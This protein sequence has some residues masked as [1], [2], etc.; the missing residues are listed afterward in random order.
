MSGTLIDNRGRNGIYFSQLLALKFAAWLE[1]NFEVWVFKTANKILFGHYKQH[2]D[3]HI[4]QEDAKTR[5][6]AAKSKL[7]VQPLQEDVIAYFEAEKDYK[8]AKAEKNK[9]IQSQ[10]KLFENL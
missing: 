1:P 9:A 4:K 6:E 5:M 10:Y 2:W 7:L 3:A 8:N